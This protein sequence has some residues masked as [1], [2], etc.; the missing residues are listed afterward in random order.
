[1]GICALTV[2][3]QKHGSIKLL[4]VYWQEPVFDAALVPLRMVLRNRFF[5]SRGDRNSVIGDEF[6]QI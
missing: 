1:M 6:N 2:I 5:D 4:N 3:G